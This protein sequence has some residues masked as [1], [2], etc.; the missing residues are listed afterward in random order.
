ME[1]K[2]L[3]I[4][5]TIELPNEIKKI[6]YHRGI[7]SEWM[8]G[9]D[10]YKIEG[11][12]LNYFMDMMGNVRYKFNKGIVHKQWLVRDNNVVVTLVDNDGERKRIPL[13][14][15]I[16][17]NMIDNPLNLKYIH[18]KDGNRKNTRPNNLMWVPKRSRYK[19]RSRRCVMY[20]PNGKIFLNSDVACYAMKIQKCTI[21]SHLKRKDGLYC[22][23]RGAQDYAITLTE[24]DNK[25]F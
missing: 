1:E 10:M 4:I 7:K 25:T 12:D 8:I 24:I 17:K 3:P 5:D 11:Y 22:Y 19:Q 13:A 9:N 6:K 20:K 21:Q 15:L 23:I 18:F 14:K 2:K 16:A